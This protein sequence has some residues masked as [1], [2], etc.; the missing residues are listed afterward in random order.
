MATL[1]TPASDSP[2]AP[3]ERSGSPLLAERIPASTLRPGMLAGSGVTLGGSRIALGTPLGRDAVLA[4]QQQGDDVSVLSGWSAQA[5]VVGSPRG[6]ARAAI[7]N[8][9]LRQG[10]YAQPENR[11]RD[12]AVGKRAKVAVDLAFATASWL[13]NVADTIVAYGFRRR[14]L[15][16]AAESASMSAICAAANG[17]D[18]QRVYEVA[19]GGLLCDVGMLFMDERLLLKPGRFTPVERRQVEKHVEV[20]ARL[21]GPLRRVAPITV[22]IVEEHQERVDGTGYPAGLSGAAFSVEGQIVGLTRRYLA[23]VVPSHDR[24][25]L[26]PHLAMDI[27]FAEADGLASAAVVETFARSIAPL[28]R[29]EVVKLTDGRMGVVKDVGDAPLRPI[30]EVRWDEIAQPVTPYDV[31]LKHHHTL[32]ALPSHF[33]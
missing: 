24:P 12:A 10:L 28:P 31:D 1:P 30:I 18:D 15:T 29:G 7:L 19:L 11:A 4:L 2:T 8:S 6:E 17:W 33:V 22:R 21:L 5:E 26:E 3:A 27:A 16:Q 14:F 20:G 25:A 13:P 23:A 32:F 9:L